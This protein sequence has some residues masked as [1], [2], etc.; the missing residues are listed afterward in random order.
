KAAL[1]DAQHDESVKAIILC[2]NGKAFCAGGD[3]SSFGRKPVLYAVKGF[4]FTSSISLQLRS[5]SKPVIAAIHGYAVGAGVS[6]SLAADM[7]IADQGTKI[8]MSHENVGFVPD[9]GGLFFLPRLVGSWK[10]KESIF[11]GAVIPV[12]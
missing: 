2:G 12:E 6:L 11:T 8:G 4:S 9:C 1:D 3:I 10:A 5:I 7:I